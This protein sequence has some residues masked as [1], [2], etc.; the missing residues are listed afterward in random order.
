MT[1]AYATDAELMAFLSTHAVVEESERL[2]RRA[3]ELIDSVIRTPYRLTDDGLPHDETIAAALRDACCA[4]V[5]QWLEV[6]EHND[7]D[8]LAGSHISVTGYSGPRAPSIAPRALRILSGA[9]LFGLSTQGPSVFDT[10][11][12]T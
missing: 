11:V 8:G 2:R 7:I 10:V 9:G 1:V 4:Q 3:S 12:V 5:E 6:G